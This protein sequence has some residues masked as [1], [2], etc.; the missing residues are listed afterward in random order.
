MQHRFHATVLSIA[1]KLSVIALFNTIKL[2]KTKTGIALSDISKNNCQY[3][4]W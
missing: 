2:R 3:L 4:Q 1:F